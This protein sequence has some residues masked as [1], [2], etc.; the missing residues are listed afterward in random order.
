MTNYG[1]VRGENEKTGKRFAVI[2][3]PVG[4]S[5][6]PAIHN[7]VYRE[8]GVDWSYKAI[9]CPT[10]QDALHQIDLV[11][12]GHLD[13]INITMPYKQLAM[14]QADL[15]DVSAVAAGGAN[16]L[17][18]RG[19]DLC[20]YNTDGLGAVD[21]IVRA[22]N[23]DVTK[24]YACVCG[25]GPTSSA[26]AC[27]L[28]LKGARHVTLFSRS[29][30]KAQA[31]VEHMERCLP[32]TCAGLLEPAEYDD[33]FRIVPGCNVFVDA[34]P[35]GM[36]PGDDPI[37]DPAFFHDGQVVMDVVYAHGVTKIVEGA[38]KRG[39]V[40]IDGGEMLI[41]QAALAIEIWQRELGYSFEIDRNSMRKPVQAQANQA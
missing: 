36:Q 21:A 8:A 13:G 41:G 10:P 37:V 38:R 28:A 12:L 33:A 2:G 4:H 22:G 26:I 19:R 17:V 15:V 16:V 27:A 24:I 35:V 7:I 40:A 29:L 30:A 34:T 1:G 6:S 39:A 20:A 11:R 32:D 14:E 23:L 9:E 25:T 3:T 31:A 5:L 18:R